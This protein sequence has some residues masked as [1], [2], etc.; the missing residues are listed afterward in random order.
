M[1]ISIGGRRGFP[2]GSDGDKGTRELV[3]ASARKNYPE[4]RS[5]CDE[6]TESV[7]AALGGAEGRRLR[8]VPTPQR[9]LFTDFC[10]P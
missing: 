8:M 6:T 9:D 5:T 10:R 3:D 1:G 4:Q 7:G 2:P